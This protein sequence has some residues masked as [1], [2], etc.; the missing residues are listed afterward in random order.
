MARRP[1]N[2]KVV[3]L[4]RAPQRDFKDYSIGEQ[5]AKWP[6]PLTRPSPQLAE[7]YNAILQR[8]TPKP[9]I[10]PDKLPISTNR[11]CYPAS[12]RSYGRLAT[13]GIIPLSPGQPDHSTGRIAVEC[14]SEEP[15]CQFRDVISLKPRYRQ[16]IVCRQT[17][18]VGAGQCRCSVWR[19]T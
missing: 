19:P 18:T 1:H 5:N 14:S 7:G 17:R 8:A 13:R 12:A 4:N 3:G 16:L 15:S 11:R 9:D 2:L 6:K 10:P